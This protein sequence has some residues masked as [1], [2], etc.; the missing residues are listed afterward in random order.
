MKLSLTT[1]KATAAEL[2]EHQSAAPNYGNNLPLSVSLDD[3][4]QPDP[5]E[6]AVA[7]YAA[8]HASGMLLQS[9]HAICSIWK[10][11]DTRQANMETACTR[12]CS[13]LQACDITAESLPPT[14]EKNHWQRSILIMYINSD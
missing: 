5:I 7:N 6:R 12:P 13:A 4:I 3:N 14:H 9:N 10:Y 1:N 8:Y 11:A 2:I